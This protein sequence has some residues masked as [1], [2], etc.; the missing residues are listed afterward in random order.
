MVEAVS[1]EWGYYYPLAEQTRATP[2]GLAVKVV[3]A[4]IQPS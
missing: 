1:R 4:L 2:F 3:W